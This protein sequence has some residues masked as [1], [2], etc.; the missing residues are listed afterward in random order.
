MAGRRQIA[1]TYVG[2]GTENGY[3]LACPKC[4]AVNETPDGGTSGATTAD[5]TNWYRFDCFCGCRYKAKNYPMEIG[6][7]RMG[8]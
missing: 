5:G 4:K 3:K 6:M 1:E 8:E 2:S 7:T